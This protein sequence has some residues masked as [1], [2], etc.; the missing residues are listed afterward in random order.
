MAQ[1]NEYQN[2]NKEEP[3]YDDPKQTK[4]PR[5]GK[6]CFKI[7]NSWLYIYDE[8]RTQCKFERLK[9]DEQAMAIGGSQGSADFKKLARH[10]D[11][12][13][14]TTLMHTACD[15]LRRFLRN[16]HAS[17]FGKNLIKGNERS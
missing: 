13:C 16:K 2:V 4:I 15:C 7:S 17:T 3:F 6:F 9:H 1:N 10:D 5:T 11:N 12:R 14:F 8:T